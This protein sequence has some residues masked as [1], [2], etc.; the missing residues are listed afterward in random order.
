MIA[1]AGAAVLTA[2]TAAL[3]APDAGATPPPRPSEISPSAEPVVPIGSASRSGYTYR[4]ACMYDFRPFDPASMATW[5]GYGLYTA[6]TQSA[7]RAMFDVPPGALLRDVEWYVYNRSTS[8]VFAYVYEFAAGQGTIFSLS[9]TATIPP[10][11]TVTPV[12]VDVPSAGRGPFGIGSKLLAGLTTPTDGTVQVNGV[13]LGFT[14]G[15]ADTGLFVTPARVYDSRHGSA[16]AIK[17]GKTRTI[18][19]P[20][21][22]IPPGTTGAFLKVAALDNTKPGS[23]TVYPA[24]GTRPAG[25]TLRFDNVL[26]QTIFPVAVSHDAKIDVHATQTVHVV[27]DVLGTIG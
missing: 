5:G 26:S 16:G 11:T 10:S 15:H 3:V 24:G 13:R 9:A 18:A 25:A 17:A 21:D 1:G 4:T 2:A 6:G 23:V 19:L 7:L 14:N 8:N 12:R 22:V 20:L 27:I